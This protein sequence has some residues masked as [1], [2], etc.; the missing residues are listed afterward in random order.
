[1]KGRHLTVWGGQSRN[2]GGDDTYDEIRVT[3]EGQSEQTLGKKDSLVKTGN[4]ASASIVRQQTL[5]QCFS[6]YLCPSPT[7]RIP[8]WETDKGIEL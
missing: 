6:A 3:D 8:F 7:C 5:K 4:P 2:P 1:M